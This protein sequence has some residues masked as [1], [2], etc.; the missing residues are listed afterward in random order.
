M[1]DELQRAIDTDF[2]VEHPN[3]QFE[4]TRHAEHEHEHA[5]APYPRLNIRAATAASGC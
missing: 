3:I 1:L 4:S 2:D 5:R